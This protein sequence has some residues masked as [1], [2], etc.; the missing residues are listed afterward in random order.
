MTQIDALTGF[1][2]NSQRQLSPALPGR[3]LVLGGAFVDKTLGLYRIPPVGGDSY[4]QELHTGV[5]G[6]ALNVAHILRQL[7]LP[8]QI[9]VPIGQGPNAAY[10]EDTLRSEG[11]GDA[12]F[13]KPYPAPHEKAH[14]CGYCM[15]LVDAQGERT[16]IVV[17][18]V[19]NIMEPSWLASAALESCD[20]IYLSGFDLTEQNG[21]VYLKEIA[22]RKRPE[23]AVYFDAGARVDFI[24]HQA[25]ELLYSLNPILHMNLLELE[26]L[27]GTSNLEEGLSELTAHT[28]SPVIVTLAEKGS[29][30]ALKADNPKG[31]V[32]L[33]KPTKA[34]PLI[35]ATG[36]GDAH[37]AGIIAALVQGKTIEE[38]INYGA[39]LSALAVGQIGARLTLS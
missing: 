5:G 17:P 9:Q 16:F 8:H 12:S 28:K 6:C 33:D 10:I 37:S 27:T 26:L 29:V 21:L 1:K 34:Q 4:A 7:K 35:D 23:C 31:Y 36:A 15:C 19:E 20:L 18:G 13:I 22:A 25:R 32:R 11:Y 30:L 24:T 39:E 3:V 38:G 14:D 2:L